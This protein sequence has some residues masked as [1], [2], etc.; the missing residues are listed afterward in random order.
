MD[1]F[2]RA[3][4]TQR[5]Y[6]RGVSAVS[7]RMSA[8]IVAILAAPCAVAAEVTD[9]VSLDQPAPWHPRTLERSVTSD[10][11][12]LVVLGRQ[13]RLPGDGVADTPSEVVVG[14]RITV[15]GG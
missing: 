5:P 12:G 10:G 15:E 9:A 6:H 3:R 8:A 1:S 14:G 7:R 4:R 13:V 2:S 11:C